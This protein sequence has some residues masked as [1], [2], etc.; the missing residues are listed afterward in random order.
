MAR[1]NVTTDTGEL[2]EQFV[3]HRSSQVGEDSYNIDKITALSSLSNEI[4]DAVRLAIRIETNT[5]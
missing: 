5:A 4:F 2:I 1:I 3:A